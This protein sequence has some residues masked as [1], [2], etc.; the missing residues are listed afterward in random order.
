MNMAKEYFPQISKIPFEGPESKNPLAFHYYDP[1]KVVLGKK[2]EDMNAV[3][4]GAGAA[5]ISI[6][7][8]LMAFG[9]GNVVL[10]NSKGALCPGAA[11]MNPAQAAMAEITNKDFPCIYVKNADKVFVTTVK[12]TTSSLT[13]SGTFTE[14]GN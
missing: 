6:C 3:I 8:L 14:D 5:G 2:M 1:E 11:G 9:I 7:K 10:V 4:S 13:V 12:G